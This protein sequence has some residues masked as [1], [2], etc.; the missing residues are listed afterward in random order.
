MDRFPPE[1]LGIISEYCDDIVDLRNFRLLNK[2]C[3][4]LATPI[5]F[6]KVYVCFSPSSFEK[7]HAISISSLSRHVESL[8]Y[9]A[10]LLP[11]FYSQDEWWTTLKS[12]HH[13]NRVGVIRLGDSHHVEPPSASVKDCRFEAYRRFYHAQNYLLDNNIDQAV[14]TAALYQLGNLRQFD[15]RPSSYRAWGKPHT[16]C[17]PI[18]HRMYEETL[19]PVGRWG[20]ECIEISRFE[21]LIKIPLLALSLTGA[22]IQY[23][24][25]AGLG[26]EARP[27]A[28][29]EKELSEIFAPAFAHLRRI[30]L[31]VNYWITLDGSHGERTNDLAE[32]ICKWLRNAEALEELEVHFIDNY[33][34]LLYERDLP[35]QPDVLQSLSNMKWSRLRSINLH[36]IFTTEKT[37]LQIIQ[38]QPALVGLELNG[39]DFKSVQPSGGSWRSFIRDLS[40]TLGP[41]L[42]E[43]VMENI[44]E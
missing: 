27:F 21:R 22:R 17:H 3:N 5:L 9:F 36:D 43:V 29:L 26:G 37:L 39:I 12:M 30:C 40:L 4:S 6:K 11:D 34:D 24:E 44:S 31:D 19:Y 18:W 8:V 32:G 15:I 13:G 10:D 14:L 23:L 38:N 2:T 1:L 7:L 16:L 33:H 41:Q 25:I 35:P 28:W 20:V 42:R